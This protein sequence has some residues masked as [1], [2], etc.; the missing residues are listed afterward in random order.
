MKV[1][2]KPGII[3]L[4]LTKNLPTLVVPVLSKLIAAM[5]VG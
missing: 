3:K 4:W 1:L 5:E 2:T